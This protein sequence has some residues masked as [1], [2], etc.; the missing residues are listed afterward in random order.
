MVPSI[1]LSCGIIVLWNMSLANF[2]V[3]ELSSQCIIGDLSIY[4]K[5]KWR[6]AS[7]YGNKD[8]YKRREL[9][10]KL[11][12]HSTEETPMV[13]GGDFNCLTSSE[14]KRRRKKFQFSKGPKEM[15]A[16]FTNNDYH[17]VRV[18]GPRFTWCNNKEGGAHIL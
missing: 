6:V 5:I 8:L 18:I 16:F 17:E 11:E 2:F 12:V 4:K 15:E 14:D 1:G 7:V 3:L 13:I 9:W 10:N